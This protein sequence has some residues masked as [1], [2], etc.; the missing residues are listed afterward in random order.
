MFF[1]ND[2]KVEV[3]VCGVFVYEFF[4]VQFI[5][6]VLFEDVRVILLEYLVY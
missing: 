1:W 5:L 4:V 3:K 6:V 2:Y